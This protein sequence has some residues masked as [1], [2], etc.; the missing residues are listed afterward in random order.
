MLGGQSLIDDLHSLRI[1]QVYVQI[2]VLRR[3]L[4]YIY[5]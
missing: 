1:S 5:I 3:L 4:V 2:D